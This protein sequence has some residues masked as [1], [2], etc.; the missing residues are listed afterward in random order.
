MP[1][2]LIITP[3][4]FAIILIASAGKEVGGFIIQLPEQLLIEAQS[5]AFNFGIQYGAMA[6]GQAVVGSKF[7]DPTAPAKLF[8][9]GV[10]SLTSASSPE[11]AANRGTIAATVLILSSLS[12]EDPN[13]SLT[14]GGFLLV[15]AQNV[16][17]PGS[18]VI[19]SN[20]L[21]KFYVLK[22]ILIRVITEIRIERKI[23]KLKL[24]RARFKFKIFRKQ[25]NKDFIFKYCRF[26]KRKIKILSHD[27]S[28]PVPYQKEL[29]IKHTVMV[30]P[31]TI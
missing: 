3:R 7:V 21:L 4:A 17:L 26:K 10:E 30:K 16:L 25:E 31:I 29:I 19:F 5:R 27:I 2:N 11:E 20:G 8:V 22:N 28:L 13:A 12:S 14:F 18:Q 15:L 1:N 23:R 6:I 24:P 9:Q